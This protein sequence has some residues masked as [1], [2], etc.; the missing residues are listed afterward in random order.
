VNV[1]ETE[2]VI[3]AIGMW[4]AGFLTGI[5]ATLLILG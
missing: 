5:A 2:A 3:I 4:V 1:H